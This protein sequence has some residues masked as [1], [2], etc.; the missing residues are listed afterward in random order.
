MLD[1][2]SAEGRI[3]MALTVLEAAALDLLDTIERE[4]AALRSIIEG[5]EGQ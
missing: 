3:L 4:R 2:M 5:R 1:S